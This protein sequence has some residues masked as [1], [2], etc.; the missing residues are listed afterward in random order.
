MPRTTTFTPKVLS[1]AIGVI[2]AQS[3]LPTFAQDDNNVRLEEVI[4]T[5]QKRAENIQDVPISVAAVTGEK[6][7]DAG[8]ENLEDLTAYLPNIHFTESGFSTQVRVRGIGSDNSQGFE[9]SVGMYIDGIYHG[10]AQLFRTPMMDMA[11]AELLRG[12]QSTLFGK[13]SVSGALNLTTAAPTEEF[14]ARL[15]GSYEFEHEQE[16]I[17]GVISGPISDELRGRIAFRTYEEQGYYYNSFKDVD[18]PDTEESAVRVS[19]DW[20]PTENL[21]FLLKAEQNDFETLGRAIEI[22]QDVSLV[23]GATYQQWLSALSAPTIDPEFDYVRQTDIGEFSDNKITNITLTTNYDLNDYTLTFVTGHLAFDYTELCDCDFTAAEILELEL[24]EDYSQLSQEIRITSP[25]GET[26][27]WVGGIFYQDYEQTFEDRLSIRST[28]LLPPVINVPVLADS[29]AGRDFTQDSETIALF[30]RV[31]WNISDQFNII[32]GARYTQEEKNSTKR[33][34]LYT[35]STGVETTD[36][37]LGLVYANPDLFALQSEASPGGHNL[38]GSRDESPFDPLAIIE[39]NIDDDTMAYVS[40]TTGSKAGGFDPR[41]N[42]TLNYEFEDEDS[43]A[44][45]VGIKNTVLDGRGEFNIAIFRTEYENLQISQFDGAVGFNVGNAKE[46]LVQGLEIDGRWAIADGVTS[47]FGMSWLDFEYKDF[48]NGNCYAGQTPDGID[49]DGDGSLD[50]CDYTGKRGVY[51]PYMTINTS[52]D[53]LTA[54]TDSMNFIGFIDFQYVDSHQ[55]HVN[56]DPSGEIDAYAIL[57]LR[58]GV[59]GENWAV[60]LLGKNL[61]DTEVISYSA[62]A[63]LSEGSF[64]TN[65]HYSFVRRPATFALE[66]TIKF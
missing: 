54:I 57:N 53:Y 52:L 5:A 11:R 35:P 38:S 15:T 59:E 25:L 47:S 4:V 42:N 8:I 13:N 12:P 50:T 17:N 51:T 26:F 37:T 49:L 36:T 44:L 56:L 20:T 6:L 21:S 2:C 64:R 14:E 46:T 10:R 19:L 34:F 65:T 16:E 55:V 9:Q 1:L 28:N 27:E 58:L 60:G 30:G 62:N 22:T 24:F 3:A 45:E 48:K 39:Y 63:P 32:L 40:Y 23:G 18:E 31:K 29:G 43:A 7:A 41:S 33:L 61:L 66:G